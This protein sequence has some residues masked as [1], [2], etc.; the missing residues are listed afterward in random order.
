MSHPMLLKKF[1][2]LTGRTSAE[3]R[4]KL[5][6]G[7]WQYG[8]HVVKDPDGKLNVIWEGY[9]KWVGLTDKAESMPLVKFKDQSN[10]KV[11]KRGGKRKVDPNKV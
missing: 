11:P 4:K 5:E 10:G 6:R 1:T 2:Q 9:Q 7:T 3:V 8:T